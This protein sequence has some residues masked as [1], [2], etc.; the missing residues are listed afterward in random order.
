MILKDKVSNTK[1]TYRNI[2]VHWKSATGVIDREKVDSDALFLFPQSSAEE[3]S[4]AAG[5][6]VKIV[7]FNDLSKLNTHSA[8]LGLL[9][10]TDS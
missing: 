6:F 10:T 3:R 2:V 1:L 9:C 8:W 4:R 7:V 5:E